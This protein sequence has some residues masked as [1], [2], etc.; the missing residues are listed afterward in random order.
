MGIALLDLLYFI[1][2]KYFIVYLFNFKVY[3]DM[4]TKSRLI[5]FEN[6]H[7]CHSLPMFMHVSWQ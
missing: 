7:G 5:Y 1:N 2:V 4:F 3:F 6:R